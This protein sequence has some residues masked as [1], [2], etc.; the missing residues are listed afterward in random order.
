M[1][2]HCK[3]FV[4]DLA[5]RFVSEEER[6]ITIARS[7]TDGAYVLSSAILCGL[8]KRIEEAL[9]GRLVGVKVSPLTLPE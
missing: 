3:I 2:D 4:M 5:W 9:C 1:N 7:S 8:S 6:K